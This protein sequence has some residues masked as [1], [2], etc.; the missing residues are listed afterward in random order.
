MISVD[1]YFIV[2]ECILEAYKRATYLNIQ[3]HFAS[4][5]LNNKLHIRL[6]F[7]IICSTYNQFLERGK[8]LTNKLKK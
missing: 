5:D 1:L 8:L 4:F 7:N 6:S 2:A 3:G